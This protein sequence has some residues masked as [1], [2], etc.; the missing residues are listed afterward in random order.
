MAGKSKNAV[1]LDID[2]STSNHARVGDAKAAYVE[3]LEECDRIGNYPRRAVI[4]GHARTHHC[5]FMDREIESQRWVQRGRR[6]P[7]YLQ[8]FMRESI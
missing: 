4:T 6:G 3:Y 2:G 5:Y 1:V 7:R 8:R